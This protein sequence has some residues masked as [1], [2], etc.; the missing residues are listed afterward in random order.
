MKTARNQ[1]HVHIDADAF[2]ASV[3]Q[4]LHRELAGKPLVVGQ[5]GGIVSAL[6]Y[7][8]KAMGIPR[9]MPII[10]V[11]KKYPHV[12]IVSSDFQAYGIFSN[13]MQRIIQSY[14]PNLVK[15]SV[16][17]CSADIGKW[18]SNFDEAKNLVETIQQ[19]LTLK[20]GCTFSFGIARTPLL[21]KLASGLN[22]PNGIS[23]LTDE[24]TPEMIYHMPV[25][26]ISGIG[27]QSYAKLKKYK[28]QTIGDFAAA[29][30]QWL[31]FNFSSTIIPIQQQ[32]LGVVTDI[33]KQKEGIKSMSRDRT[34][35]PTENYDYLYS[36][37]S[38]N[39]EHLAKR[40][41]KL[42]LFTKRIGIKLR[43]QD[44]NE[45]Q[46]FI[47]LDSPSRAPED[48]FEKVSEL[49]QEV[50][51]EHV[52]YRQVS[53]TCAGLTTEMMQPD[54]FG[55][56]D[57]SKSKDHVLSLIDALENKFGMSCINLATSLQAK[58]KLKKVYSKYNEG[59]V[60]PHAL[61]PGE[62]VRKRLIYPFLGLV[63]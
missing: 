41:R 7:P 17:E 58:D 3:E 47:T 62:E 59:D 5:N 39:I 24:N 60:Y 25:N 36:Q 35:P 13:R 40:M 27:K 26:Y 44:L 51:Q 52:L 23:I 2:F 32:I 48:L 42:H 43:D 22:K 63:N 55:A 54:L 8:A 49:L 34:F 12:T 18:V 37:A 16:D 11:R 1:I 28:I 19:E 57:I 21:A 20:L 53:I 6:S 9:V 30:Q 46:S 61:L 29:D 14:L 56:S 4:V 33:P 10:S 50:Y 45:N 31:S 38:L 15:N